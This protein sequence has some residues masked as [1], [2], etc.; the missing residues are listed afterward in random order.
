M[1]KLLLEITGKSIPF[2]AQLGTG[3]LFC[4]LPSIIGVWYL[5]WLILGWWQGGVGAVVI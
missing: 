5:S 2:M 1:V 3:A 4:G